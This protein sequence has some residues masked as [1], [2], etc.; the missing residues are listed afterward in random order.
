VKGGYY[1]DTIDASTNVHT[2]VLPKAD[3]GAFDVRP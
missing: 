3:Y 2:R 1:I